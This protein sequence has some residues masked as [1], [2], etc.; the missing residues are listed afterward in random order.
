MK[1]IGFSLIE[2]LIVISI[3]LVIFSLGIASFNQFNKRERVRQSALSL[4]ASLRLAQSKALS[5]EKPKSDCTTYQGVQVSFTASSYTLQHVC[6]PEGAAGEATTSTF[7][8]GVTFETTPTTFTYLSTNTLDRTTDQT[9]T[10]TDGRS[11]YILEILQN[12][13]INDRGFTN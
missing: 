6:D 11:S 4:K 13:V 9:I 7:T 1:R 8:P 12:G 3:T 2:L 5:A 10:I